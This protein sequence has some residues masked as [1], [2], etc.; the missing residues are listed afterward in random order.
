MKRLFIIAAT[1]LFAAVACQKNSR[2]AEVIDDTLPAPVLFKSNLAASVATKSAGALEQWSGNETLYIY[3]IERVNGNNDFSKE[4]FINNVDAVSP[5]NVA[6]GSIDVYRVKATNEYYY[7]AASTYY[8]FYG[9]YIDDAKNGNPLAAAAPQPVIDEAAGTLTLPVQIS[10]KEDIMLAK[11]DPAADIAGNEKISDVSKVYG[12][13][14]ARRGVVPNLVFN[15]CLSR[16]NFKIKAGNQATADNI[17]VAGMT[18]SSHD[19]ATLLIASNSAEPGLVDID[20]DV[21]EFPLQV[22]SGNSLAPLSLNDAVKPAYKT[23]ADD[24]GDDF[25]EPVLV[26]PGDK[27]YEVKLSLSQKDY[28][29]NN[30]FDIALTIDFDKLLVGQGETKDSEAVAGH[31]YDV[32]LIVYGLEKVDVKVTLAQW[33]SSGSFIIDPDV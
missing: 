25:G 16:F 20:A 4:P 24:P 29:F 12:A 13:Y 18:I 8:N 22:R 28:S 5:A 31:Q 33:Q 7:Y 21:V 17:T 27:T 11:A 23:D 14:A 26:I 6:S 10:G 19:K 9:Y 30:P 32:T 3:G 2:N 1:V 15:H